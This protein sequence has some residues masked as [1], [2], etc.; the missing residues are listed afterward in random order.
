MQLFSNRFNASERSYAGLNWTLQV[1]TFC[2]PFQYFLALKLAVSKILK[3]AYFFLHAWN[4]KGFWP[5]KFILIVSK[6]ILI[7]STD[8]NRSTTVWSMFITYRAENS[9]E[10]LYYS[11][12]H[13]L[14]FWSGI[15]FASSTRI[16]WLLTSIAL[17]WRVLI[18]YFSLCF[19]SYWFQRSSQVNS[20]K[21]FQYCTSS[22]SKNLHHYRL[23]PEILRRWTIWS[24]LTTTVCCACWFG[25]V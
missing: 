17:L 7:D 5:H 12:C 24:I 14:L 15:L 3:L 11:G 10:A 13:G 25:Q 8:K 21:H 19:Y 4:K 22:K 20:F 9:S 23:V 1:S 2:W 18:F 16:L 6:P